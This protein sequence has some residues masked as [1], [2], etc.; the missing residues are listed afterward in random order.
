MDEMGA[1]LD[2]P[3]GRFNRRPAV[4]VSVG[5]E[6]SQD[7]PSVESA[8]SR[9]DADWLLDDDQDLGRPETFDGSAGRGAEGWVAVV[10]WIGEAISNN[11]IDIALGYAFARL[12]ARLREWRERRKAEGKHGGFEISRGGAA[13]LAASHVAAE[14]GEEG[15]LEI[16]A[17]EEPSSIA[18]NEISEISFVGV[19]PWIV[20]LRNPDRKIRYVA[21]VKP[22]GDVVDA[23]RVPFL[24]FEDMFLHPS[25]FNER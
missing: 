25:R 17:V 18:G 14:F 24:P 3:A 19:E 6:V 11:V 13:L 4:G 1:T 7:H 5:E 20:L 15:P 2:A 23:L 21:V 10:Q 9:V 12:I 16:E 22:D 8:L